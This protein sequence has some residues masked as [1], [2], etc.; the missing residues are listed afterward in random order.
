M[1]FRVRET[2]LA[3]TLLNFPF[4]NWYPVQAWKATGNKRI[5]LFQ[6]E[7]SSLYLCSQSRI[8]FHECVI[9][10]SRNDPART[11]RDDRLSILDED[12]FIAYYCVIYRQLF[13]CVSIITVFSKCND[14]IID[15]YI[16]YRHKSVH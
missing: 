3:L 13:V 12:N 14:A 11:A 10:T 7:I 9:G 6:L 8:L 15:Y 2:W 1:K 16:Y 4:G 5:L